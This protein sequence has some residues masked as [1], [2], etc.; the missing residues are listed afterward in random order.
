MSEINISKNIIALRKSKGI[1]QEQ[2]AQ[3]INVSAQAVSKWETETCMPDVQTLP[4][5]A[6][7][8]E[9]SIDFLY[10]GKNMA[11]N[12]IYEKNFQKVVSHPQMCEDSYRDAFQLFASAHFGVS[13]NLCT[14]NHA[15][16]VTTTFGITHIS[17]EGGISLADGKGFGAIIT[18][19]YFETISNKTID[20][21]IP[22]LKALGDETCFK[23]VLAILSM[24]DISHY[25]LLETLAIDETELNRGLEILIENK[26][27]LAE[28]S[29]HKALGTTYKIYNMYHSGLCV[30]LA[31]LETTRAGL[32]G[33]SCCMG[34]GDY[35][36][37]I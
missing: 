27:V 26:I 36:I 11:Y 13:G 3:A 19:K 6:E 31:S 18:R 30:L 32:D 2:L 9:V 15:S 34:Y 22:V 16:I 5:I 33:I 24:S 20:F 7:F 35:P 1:T 12:D 23:I 14:R 10:H 29:K 17:S 37:N 25:E 4:L 21:S 28:V 8:F